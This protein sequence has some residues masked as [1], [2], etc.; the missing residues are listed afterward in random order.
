MEKKKL[1]LAGSHAGSTAI[2]VIEEIKKRNL[3]WEIHWV[4]MEYKNMNKYDVVFHNL[5]SGKIE[6]KFTKNT[7]KSFLKIPNSFLKGRKIIKEIKPDLTLSFGSSA[8]AIASFWSSF[9]DIPVVLHEQTATAGRA[10][11][12]SSYFA[13]Q[14]LI[15]RESSLPFFNKNKTKIVGNP[16]NR[17]IIKYV[18]A[19]KLEDKKSLRVK[20][21]L[22]T[23]GSRGSKWINDAVK[24]L[25]PRLLERYYVI[26]QTG[27]N[28]I[29]EFKSIDNPKYF[30]FGLADT[31]NMAEI[32]AK[33]DIVISRSGANTC[34][35]LLALKKPSILIPIPWTYNDEA[36]ENAKY[37]KSLGLSRILPQNELSPQRLLAEIEILISDYQNIVKKTQNI[38]SPDLNASERVVDI[39]QEQI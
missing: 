26:H 23:G 14:I 11:I 13:K 38:E 32:L 33:S 12:I 2:A 29:E 20:S 30:K 3:N 18:L 17:E 6:N 1:L 4:G 9:M 28:N 25:L 22:I 10:N 31:K 27:D 8:G 37:L 35:E 15:S 24:P 19:N 16:L 39:L 34:W 36:N 21:I 7:I 5:E